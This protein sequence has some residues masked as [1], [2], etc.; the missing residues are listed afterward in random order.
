MKNIKI[1]DLK[2]LLI[3]IGF[4]LLLIAVV[5]IFCGAKRGTNK[6]PTKIEYI[7]YTVESGDTLWSIANQVYG[8]SYDTR[9]G[10]YDIREHNNLT[11]CTIRPNDTI[12]IPIR[13]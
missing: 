1:T 13:K 12:L 5:F 3:S 11:D 9:R 8:N 2:R 6:A 7:E 10:V 4:L